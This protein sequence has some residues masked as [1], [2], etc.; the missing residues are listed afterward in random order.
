M[1]DSR[2]VGDAG[3]YL[4]AAKLA[5]RGWATVLTTSGTW[6]TDL[7]AQVGDDHLPVAI[8]VKTKSPGS[9]NFQPGSISD[10]AR[11]GAN[12]WVVLVALADDPRF[13]VVPRDIVVATVKAFDLAIGG[14]VALGEQ[15]FEA[16]QN[17]WSLLERPA[18]KH[19]WRLPQWVYERRDDMEWAGH[20]GV[21]EDTEIVR[22]EP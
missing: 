8:Q 18:W 17:E 7:L 15:E 13:Y 19:R 3:T 14:R 6:R 11:E 20:A 10:P 21:P 2:L 5:L 9:K 4:V 22:L 1:A 12:E 16:Y